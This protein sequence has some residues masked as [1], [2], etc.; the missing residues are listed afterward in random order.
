MATKWLKNISGQMIQILTG[1]EETPTMT[2]GEGET[3]DYYSIVIEDPSNKEYNKPL[4]DKYIS[5]RILTTLEG[6]KKGVSLEPK[7]IFPV[8]N[9][10]PAVTTKISVGDILHFQDATTQ[11]PTAWTW[12]FDLVGFPDTGSVTFLEGTNANSQNPI[13]QFNTSG[14]YT[15]SLTAS[16]TGFQ[17]TQ[18]KT[19]LI[20]CAPAQ[21]VFVP[22]A[23]FTPTNSQYLYTG[24]TVQFTD[25]SINTPTSWLWSISK[26]TSF[27][28]TQLNS[29]TDIVYVDGTSNESQNPKVQFN[30]PGVYQVSLVASNSAGTSLPFEVP[31]SVFAIIAIPVANFDPSINQTAEANS[32]ETTVHFTDTSINSPTAWKWTVFKVGEVAAEVPIFVNNTTSNSKNP[33]IKFMSEGTY[34]VQLVASNTS[35]ASSPFIRNSLITITPGRPVVSWLPVS[36]AILKDAVVAFTDTSLNNPISWNWIIRNATFDDTTGV[37]FVSGS[38]ASQNPTVKFTLA[39]TYNITLE[40]TNSVGTGTTT[41]LDTI[42]VSDISVLTGTGFMFGLYEGTEPKVAAW[43]LENMTY[44]SGPYIYTGISNVNITSPIGRI[45][46]EIGIAGLPGVT[47]ITP[48]D[49]ITFNIQSI[50]QSQNNLYVLGNDTLGGFQF[51]ETVIG[52][53][54]NGSTATSNLTPSGSLVAFYSN[55]WVYQFGLGQVHNSNTGMALH[56]PIYTTGAD[57]VYVTYRASFSDPD[58]V[59]I[60]M[61]KISPGG[62]PQDIVLFNPENNGNIFLF[63]ASYGGSPQQFKVMNPNC[64]AASFSNQTSKAGV[65]TL[66][67]L[68]DND[69]LRSTKFVGYNVETDSAVYSPDLNSFLSGNLL[70]TSAINHGYFSTPFTGYFTVTDNSSGN[71]FLFKWD[72]SVITFVSSL[73]ISPYGLNASSLI[74]DIDGNPLLITSV[75]T[76]GT[77]SPVTGLATKFNGTSWIPQCTENLAL[78]SK[79]NYLTGPL[80]KS[81]LGG[82]D[83]I[84]SVLPGS[85]MKTVDGGLTSI[86]T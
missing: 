46:D 42:S 53:I 63:G 4:I 64:P 72:H 65:I 83:V 38:A 27:G 21:T 58:L 47:F 11:T 14:T 1:R 29:P 33:Y 13:V 12:I 50:C 45:P 19:N 55:D 85:T 77:S 22:T 78:D 35:G 23:S 31:A 48:F 76:V 52:K 74:P 40:A 24:S 18:T 20:E 2:L 84:N 9:F 7:K 67:M 15:V 57:T 62:S 8:V 73:T 10:S 39:G 70:L 30:D 66:G 43:S 51:G 49:I 5:T 71:I 82:V 54:A 68:Y 25:T 79:A 36:A 16:K 75:T 69:M 80:Y 28:P 17:G 3:I 86:I 32:S 56:T 59:G 44:T 81:L 26:N 41:R 60:G 6:I 37:E 34:S 61:L